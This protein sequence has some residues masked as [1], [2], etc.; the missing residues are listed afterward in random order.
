MTPAPSINT[1]FL[2]VGGVLLTNG[3]G[4]DARRRAAER[5]H[6]DPEAFEERHRRVYPALEIDDL[7]L[8]EYLRTT[9]FC[10]PRPF[11]PLEFREFLFTQSRAHPEMLELCREVKQAHRLKVV[12]VSNEGR[13]LNEYR[14]QRFELASLMDCFI[15]SSFVH[16][17]KPDPAIFRM[18]LDISQAQPDHVAYVDDRPEH[19]GAARN[20]G[21]H[22]IHHEDVASTRDALAA[23]GLGLSP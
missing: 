6:L 14:V 5:F 23:L 1:L 19:V 20:L 22:A 16:L 3:W 15:S 12:A 8:D 17:R 10:E 18:A 9:V 2:D 11:T 7:S 21:I 13:E 4:R